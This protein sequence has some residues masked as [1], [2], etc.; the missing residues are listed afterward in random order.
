M[1]DEA[2]AKMDSAEEEG[3]NNEENTIRTVSNFATASDEGGTNSA[4]E[5]IDPDVANTKGR[6][7]MMTIKEQIAL[8]IFYKCGHCGDPGHTKK[9]CP[10]KDKEYNLQNKKDS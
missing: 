4:I 9:G 7:R 6:P 3:L 2:L 10:N 1:V 5:L 8:G